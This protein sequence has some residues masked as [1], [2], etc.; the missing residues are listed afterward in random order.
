MTVNDDARIRPSLD[1]MVQS[2]GIV[3]EDTALR[4]AG[5]CRLPVGPR[6]N[7]NQTGPIPQGAVTEQSLENGQTMKWV[8][9]VACDAVE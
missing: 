9:S 5:G 7:G 6:R 8:S 2:V 1:Y 4:R 3:A